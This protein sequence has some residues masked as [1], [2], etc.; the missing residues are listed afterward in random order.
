M[1]GDRLV[2]IND[3]RVN[4]NNIESLLVASMKQSSTLKI[5]AVSPLTFVNLNTV[6]LLTKKDENLER[7]IKSR[8]IDK[9]VAVSKSTKVVKGDRVKCETFYEQEFNGFI[10]I[11]S[12]SKEIL[13]K[14]N[15]S[16][17]KVTLK[18]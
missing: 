9:T 3:V 18:F 1:T 12:L 17:E 8:R 15:N 10:M 4:L 2:S 7:V 6:D 13:K 5:V 11:L 16:S 14:N